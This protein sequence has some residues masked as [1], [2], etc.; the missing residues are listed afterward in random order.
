VSIAR[1]SLTDCHGVEHQ[2]EVTRFPVAENASLQL[3]LGAPLIDAVSNAISTI[4]PILQ[5]AEVRD[6]IAAAL[7]KKGPGGEVI[8]G[9][10]KVTISFETIAKVLGKANWV[11]AADVLKPLPEMILAQGGPALMTRIFAKT[12]RLTPV[13]DLQGLPNAGGP[14]VDP[15]LRQNLGTA[16]GQDAA[17]G[18]GNMREYWV[19]GAMVLIANFTPSGPDG[20]INWKGAV[21]A[22]TGGIVTL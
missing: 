9:T 11:T 3:L 12:E 13:P 1:F 16:A 15:N 10:T 17:F 5:D 2:Y 7:P 14:V 18:E 22:L 19:A 21:S 4:V 6:Q 8:E 20:S